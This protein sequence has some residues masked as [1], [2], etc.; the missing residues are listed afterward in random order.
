M[1]AAAMRFET[2]VLRSFGPIGPPAEG[3]A[4]RC[5]V[6]SAAQILPKRSEDQTKPNTQKVTPAQRMAS[7]LSPSQFMRQFYSSIQ[8]MSMLQLSMYSKNL[9]PVR[10]REDFA[11]TP[12]PKLRRR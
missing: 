8:R 1:A 7:Q 9:P 12:T 5:R 4:P 3:G 11:K 6:C 10:P 2:N